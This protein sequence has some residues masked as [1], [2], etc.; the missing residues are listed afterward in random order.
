MME[1]RVPGYRGAS[2]LHLRE[3]STSVRVQTLELPLA[4]Q[5]RYLLPKAHTLR[6]PKLIK[7]GSLGLGS[8]HQFMGTLHRRVWG[9][10]PPK[11]MGIHKPEM[12][13]SQGF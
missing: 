9:R 11:N 6:S 5:W 7:P 2:R 1:E 3:L 10:T 8:G 13:V 4:A 12:S